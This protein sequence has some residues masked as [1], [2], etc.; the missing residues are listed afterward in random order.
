MH[1]PG[2][3][4]VHVYKGHQD[5]N[6]PM[7]C[8]GMTMTEVQASE[9]HLYSVKNPPNSGLTGS[10]ACPGAQ[11]IGTGQKF[12]ILHHFVDIGTKSTCCGVD[13]SFVSNHKNHLYTTLDIISSKS[14]VWC[15]GHKD[16]ANTE[17]VNVPGDMHPGH[18]YNPVSIVNKG[19]ALKA[20]LNCMVCGYPRSIA[21]DWCGI[22]HCKGCHQPADKCACC[23][24][25]HDYPCKCGQAPTHESV[26][27][28]H[29]EYEGDG[30]GDDFQMPVIAKTYKCYTCNEHYKLCTC[31]NGPK[32]SSGE[33]YVSV[34]IATKCMPAPWIKRGQVVKL[35]PY[36]H[37]QQAWPNIRAEDRNPV[38]WAADFYLYQA[39]ASGALNSQCGCKGPCG[40]HSIREMVLI[41]DPIALKEARAR[42]HVLT[43]EI[44]LVFREYVDMACGGEVRHHPSVGSAKVL[45]SDRTIA[46]AQWRDIR[47]LVGTQALLD[48]E[49]LF[50]DYN[51]GDGG[52]AGP[53]WANAARLLHSRL[54]NRI[55]KELFVDQVFSLVHN[56]GVFL[57]KLAWQCG[58]R[59]Q[60]MQGVVLPAQARDDYDTILDYAST[61]AVQLW[62]EGWRAINYCRIRAGVRPIPLNR[63]RGLQICNVCKCPSTVGHMAYQCVNSKPTRIRDKKRAAKYRSLKRWPNLSWDM[64]TVI[65]YSDEI[66][67]YQ[68]NFSSRGYYEP[69][70][71]LEVSMVI[72][73]GKR[74]FTVTD[75]GYIFLHIPITKFKGQT[76]T[77]RDLIEIYGLTIEIR[78]PN[79]D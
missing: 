2:T 78:N 38:E 71:L 44:D 32:N 41:E 35:D 13:I 65:F 53:K 7:P 79:D 61:E 76:W 16:A 57:N 18:M 17:Y 40:H 24:M 28:D 4:I 43:D 9:G 3:N 31:K 23:A 47:R 52:I 42:L 1:G 66:R 67:M 68:S 5:P 12:Y 75:G 37:Y 15:A 50:L 64:K 46:W 36:A 54:T 6:D 74:Y 10:V 20:K 62:V 69:E 25:C 11:F 70:E 63:S 45:S 34:N 51:A 29:G 39:L 8:C 30:E 55:S 22:G 77:V 58:D 73:E 26:P 21:E 49:A 59:L 56:G 60:D 48:M 33:A 19:S 14:G 27:H 72:P